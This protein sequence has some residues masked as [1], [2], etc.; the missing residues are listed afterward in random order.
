MYSLIGLAILSF[1]LSLLLTP[2]VRW[3]CPVWGLVDHP[4]A[5]KVHGNPIPRA[6][7]VAIV[8]TYLIACAILLSTHAK[9]GDLIWSARAEILRLLPAAGFVFLVGFVD[10]VR[11]LKATPKLLGETAAALAV[12]WPAC[13]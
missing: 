13:I 6:G 12:I 2:L 9:A 4:G 1:A 5:R 10:D 8:L 11:G 7:G 3:F